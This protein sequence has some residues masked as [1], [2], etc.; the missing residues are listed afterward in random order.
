MPSENGLRAARTALAAHRECLG[1][2]GSDA[3]QLWHLLVSLAEF[4]QENG[5]DLRVEAADAIQ[6]VRQETRHA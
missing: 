6:H 5:L 3:V 4:C 2:E 1:I